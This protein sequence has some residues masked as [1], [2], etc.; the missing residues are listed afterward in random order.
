[1]ISENLNYVFGLDSLKN[2]YMN[3]FWNP[4]NR[5]KILDTFDYS[6]AVIPKGFKI[7]LRNYQLR[8]IS[9]MKSV[10]A[11]KTNDS[12]SI[13]NNHILRDET[14]RIKIKLGHSPLSLSLLI[15]REFQN[16]NNYYNNSSTTKP[17]ETSKPK[18]LRFRGGILAD[19]TGSGKTVTTLGLIHSTPFTQQKQIKRNEIFNS[20]DFKKNFMESRASCVICP[21]NIQGQWISEALK[22]NPKFKVIG[23]STILDLRKVSWIDVMKADIVVVSHQFLINSNYQKVKKDFHSIADET[24]NF[25][26]TKGR[27][28][29]EKVHFHR[30]FYDEFHEILA[31]PKQQFK[32]HLCQFSADN[33]WGLTGTPGER[34]IKSLIDL[35]PFFKLNQRFYY[36]FSENFFGRKEFLEKFFK[37]NVLNLQLPPLI[38]ETEW[39]NFSQNEM[40]LF[41][42]MSEKADDRAKIMMCCHYQL[43]EKQPNESFVAIE[44]VQKSMCKL[45][46]RELIFI[47][48]KIEYEEE[49]LK[50]LQQK[51]IDL[52]IELEILDVEDKK[53]KTAI[54]IDLVSTAS[55]IKSL[56]NSLADNNS[57]FRAAQIKFNY[58]QSVFNVLGEPDANKC[59][60][61]QGMIP[62]Q[63]LSIL[64]C[65]HVFCF[66]CVS[67]AIE[68]SLKCPICSD[69]LQDK[70]QII[71]FRLE[72]KVTSKPD[73]S[74]KL[75][76]LSP[77]KYGSK[78]IQLY[79]YVTNLI[80]NDP[81]AR[82]ILFLQYKD[83][84]DF[85][86]ETLKE[87]GI[88]YVRV[89]GNVFQRKNAI[90]RF[91]NSKDIR[92]IML[93]S[94]DS[95]SGI[96]LSQATHVILLHPFCA[97][98]DEIDLAS[99][100]QGISRAY[101]FGL[102]HPLKVV[103][104]AVRG[105]IEEAITLRRQ[106]I[107]L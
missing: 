25:L 6:E 74:P 9:W 80:D 20:E 38:N 79:R 70:N 71:R 87:L 93:S 7:N 21:S 28:I 5:E 39:V 26:T 64:P 72:P 37:R 68:T 97:H 50:S 98:G 41:E 18:P 57:K 45:K 83:L 91:C 8:S 2:A 67:K 92:L 16:N 12:N 53:R 63:S 76:A 65:S 27:V 84:A 36:I 47:E 107:T 82:I 105:T 88:D 102:N 29:I 73:E 56:I 66:A 4:D 46:K 33:I 106:N 62:A 49:Q 1:M 23:L 24:K 95:V 81:H 104:F 85:I 3:G 13:N 48:R 11:I 86:A 15:N 22:C 32:D 55:T 78:L 59:V 89:V 14:T 60:I 77:S 34:S 42:W 54:E 69:P 35:I 99:E 58:F 94:E 75:A 101:R 30:I 44:E 90:S 61:C 17:S 96:N 31:A 43:S 52:Q 51:E 10:E 100:K 103:R 19:D 40:A